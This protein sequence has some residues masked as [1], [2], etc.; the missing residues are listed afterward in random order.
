MVQPAWA[1]TTVSDVQVRTTS[2]GVEV[3]LVSDASERPQIFLLPPQ[4]NDL[5]AH[6]ADARLG[7]PGGQLNK[8]NPAPGIS[9]VEVIQLD[10]AT[11]QVTVKGAGSRPVGRI[12]QTGNVGNLVLAYTGTG[13]PVARQPEPS[14]RQVSSRPPASRQAV[15]TSSDVMVR[16]PG[17]TIDGQ[18]ASLQRVIPPTLPRAVAIPHGDIAVSDVPIRPYTVNL[19]TNQVIPRLVLRDAPV[20]EVLSLLARAGGVNIAFAEA[21]E[22]SSEGG[23][24]NARISVDIENEP[25]QDVFN[26]V[27]RISGLQAN[28][29]GQTIFVGRTLPNGARNVIVRSIRINQTTAENAAG[30]LVT[31]GAESASTASVREVEVLQINE[32]SQE[33][34]SSGSGDQAAQL[35]QAPLT[36]TTVTETTTITQLRYEPQDSI[37]ILRGLQVAVDRRTNS[38]TLVGQQ[39]LVALASEQLARIDGRVRQVAVNVRVIDINLL[40][41]ERIGTSFSFGIDGTR[42]VN[43][44]GIG[45]I[46]WNDRGAP[47]SVL[48]SSVNSIGSAP[49]S[50]NGEVFGENASPFNFG[51]DFLAQLQLAVVNNNAKI[52]TDPTLVVQEGQVAQ[53]ELTEEVVGSITSTVIANEGDP[54]TTAQVD[55]ERAG[56]VLGVQVDRID[57]NGFISLSVS[58]SLRVPIGEVDNL[59]DGGG[60]FTTL[61]S[62]RRLSSGQIRVRDGQTLVLAGIIQDT[63]R[64]TVTKIPIL[65]D[66]PLLGALFRRTE[67]DNQ[68]RELVV[69]V[70]PQ[71]IDDSNASTVGYS[72]T[73]SRD[74]QEFI[75]RSTER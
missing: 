72:Y 55:K 26:Y 61:L 52:L 59:S 12:R 19:G 10:A 64:S 14:D 60:T 48:P 27:L 4:G 58:P 69:L 3:E 16:N 2:D 54:I 39:D 31:L 18:Q 5:V 29:V 75:R 67:R 62:E 34:S 66:L 71:L 32:D 68:R 13:A 46:N 44:G 51:S 9:M 1:I 56:L 7:I 6:V 23:G 65:G 8:E 53:V 57:D 15:E 37:P 73:P 45:I 40:E 70:T 17:I 42:I 20:R 11:I 24:S 50:I 35:V 47:F 28:R 74:A 30:F 38:L 21:G 36:Q 22:E 41:T 33:Q 49:V 25:V 63:D 43:T